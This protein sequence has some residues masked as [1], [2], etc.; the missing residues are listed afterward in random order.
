[1]QRQTEGERGCQISIIIPPPPPPP[2]CYRDGNNN[3]GGRETAIGRNMDEGET[4]GGL[5]LELPR[6]SIELGS[7]PAVRWRTDVAQK[8]V[9]EKPLTVGRVCSDSNRFGQS[10]D[11]NHT[12]HTLR[13][14]ADR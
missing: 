3:S 13:A 2:P 8:S 7:V 12:T 14:R 4:L 6:P 10:Q 1:M 9:S 5:E 11:A